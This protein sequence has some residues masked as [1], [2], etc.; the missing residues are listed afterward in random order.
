M[1]QR[2]IYYPTVAQCPHYSEGHPQS[3]R[4]RENV[5]EP[6]S[7]HL[8]LQSSA[9][10]RL[11]L[12]YC[13]ARRFEQ[14][15]IADACRTSRFARSAAE[16]EIDMPGKSLRI[17]RQSPFSDGAH[18]IDPS[19]RTVVLIAEVQI[20]GAGGKTQA[21]MHAADQFIHF[22]VKRGV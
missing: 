16:T 3:F 5:T 15:S 7:K 14:E 19:A 18:E 8:L 20:C 22:R 21:A 11:M 6:E 2:K 17:R 1:G 4:L 12:E 13:F 10:F 9:L